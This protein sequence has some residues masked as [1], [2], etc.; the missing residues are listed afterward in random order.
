MRRTRDDASELR[1]LHAFQRSLG[2]ESEW[3]TRT[4]CRRLEPGLAPRVAG[5]IAAP[6]D[7]HVDPRALL[8]ALRSALSAAG[9]ELLTGADGVAIEVAGDRVTGVRAGGAHLRA[10][11]VVV[12]AGSLSGRLAGLPAEVLPPVRPVKGQILRLRTS[13]E[14]AVATRI[15]RTPRC[16]VVARGGGEVVIGATVEER[17]YDT[18]VTAD[19]VFRLLEAAIEVLPDVGEL[20]LIETAA[21]LRPGT[22]DN[23]PIVGAA[24]L[25]GLVWATGHNRNGVLLAPVTAAAVVRSLLDD[26]PAPLGDQVAPAR[27]GRALE[28]AL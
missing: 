18:A 12:A 11:R 19:G 20:E 24:P 10:D 7:H 1:R 8:G 4:E 2:L 15:V 22:P 14:G 28:A 26:D 13:S 25:P 9:G 16:Y 27:F 6:Q 17:G 21:R 3:L 5:A 23:L